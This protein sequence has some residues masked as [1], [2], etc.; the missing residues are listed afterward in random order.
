MKNSYFPVFVSKAALE[1]E[2]DHVEGFAPEVRTWRC[3]AVVTQLAPA[4]TRV[5]ARWPG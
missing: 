1:V 5:R 3:G 4:L 2:K